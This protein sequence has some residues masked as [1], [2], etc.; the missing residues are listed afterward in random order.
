M[1]TAVTY[2]PP[3]RLVRR[4]YFRHSRGVSCRVYVRE[5]CVRTLWASP[6]TSSRS[7]VSPVSPASSSASSASSHILE[8]K[9]L[10]SNE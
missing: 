8:L 3:L 10:D 1:F 2:R 9:Y 4:T 5:V 7:A 6:C